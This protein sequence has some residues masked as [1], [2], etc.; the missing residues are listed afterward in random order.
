MLKSGHGRR[1]DVSPSGRVDMSEFG[2]DVINDKSYTI[3]GYVRM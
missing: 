3:Y 2:K 1:A